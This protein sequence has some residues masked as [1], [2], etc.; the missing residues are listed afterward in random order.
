VGARD[1]ALAQ[2]AGGLP[3]SSPSVSAHWFGLDP[4]WAPLRDDPRFRQLL[5][6]AP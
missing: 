1:V 3:V 5:A 4:V 2:L 6:T